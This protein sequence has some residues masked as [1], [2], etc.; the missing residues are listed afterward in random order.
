MYYK[1]SDIKNILDDIRKR[2]LIGQIL[3]K[4]APFG[5]ADDKAIE[6]NVNYYRSQLINH[7]VVSSI[8]DEIQ[9]RLKHFEH[10]APDD[11]SLDVPTKCDGCFAQ[12]ANNICWVC[13]F[14]GDLSESGFYEKY[15]IM[16]N[17]PFLT[18]KQVDD[19]AYEFIQNRFE[20]LHQQ[21]I[22]DLDNELNEKIKQS[23]QERFEEIWGDKSD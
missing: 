21:I 9:A 13:A 20:T 8:L 2:Y 14:T 3:Q 15:G 1:D 19:L 4:P 18:Q 6:D 23:I 22:D 11:F 12:R 5:L 16:E 17:C 7:I 10:P